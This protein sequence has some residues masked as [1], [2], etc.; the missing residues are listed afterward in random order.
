VSGV[1]VIAGSDSSGG[2]GMTRD[3]D[4]LARFGARAQ[5]ALTAVTAQSDTKVAAVYPLPPQ[6][7]RAQID[8]AF[9]TGRVCAVKIGMLATR[10]GVLAVAAGLEAHPPLPVVLDP[11][12][13]STSGCPLLDVEGQAALRE[14]LLP[15]ATLITPNIAEAAALLGVASA[16]GEQELLRQ[17][18]ALLTLGARAVLL[19]G[20]H[21]RGALA[22]DYLLT[23]ATPVRRLSA[24]RLAHGHRGTGSAL[25]AAIA[26]RLA[27]GDDLLEACTRA[28]QHVTELLQLA[29]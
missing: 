4:T 23:P 27:A 24:A 28:K 5:C 14:S 10:G 20:G 2:A 16:S 7:I 18:E 19:K 12:L 21:G 22:T 1:L 15:R 26:A 11:V 29:D 8:A 9:A 25:A 17:A 6:L 13:A 3:V